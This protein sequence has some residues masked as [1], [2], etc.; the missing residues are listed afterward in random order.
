MKPTDKVSEKSM[1]PE[2]LWVDFVEDELDESFEDDLSLLLMNSQS[3]KRSMNDIRTLRGLIKSSDDVYLPEDGRIYDRMHD[4]IMAAIADKRPGSDSYFG[5]RTNFMRK[6]SS[7]RFSSM[8]GATALSALVAVA[9]WFSLNKQVSSQDQ[10]QVAAQAQVEA[11]F[12]AASAESD[13]ISSEVLNVTGDDDFVVD[14]A[15]RKV[16]SMSDQDYQ[17]LLNHLRD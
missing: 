6:F 12:L 8:V 7:V 9:G 13:S 2:D 4:N 10:L 3:D 17:A 15:S 1:A 5:A 11:Q 14:A 16:A